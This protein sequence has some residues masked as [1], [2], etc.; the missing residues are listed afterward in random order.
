MQESLIKLR[1]S[2]RNMER[3][4]WVFFLMPLLVY[5]ISN[6]VQ[7][8]LVGFWDEF[9]GV[10]PF[11]Y[12]SSIIALCL[13]HEIL[14][15]IGGVMAGAKMSSFDIGFDR[16]DFSIMFGCRDSMTIGGYQIT[17]LM[18]F[19][20]MTPFLVGM[21]YI[22]ESHVWWHML[23]LSTSGCVFDLTVSAGLMWI[24]TGT[25]IIPDLKGEDGFVFLREA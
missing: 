1:I 24:P 12:I 17:L 7:F 21:A 23:M 13:V 18:P 20:V 3:I 16:K 19:I 10:G 2:A 14:H 5:L 4:Y 8:G 9:I 25:R 15:A 11:I 6:I 22:S